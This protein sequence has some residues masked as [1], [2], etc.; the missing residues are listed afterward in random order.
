MKFNQNACC[1]YVFIS[2]EKN[3][4]RCVMFLGL[5]F[6]LCE[7]DRPFFSTFNS[8]GCKMKGLKAVNLLKI[9]KKK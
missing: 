5:V 9:E 1:C 4:I 3:M 2:L 7:Y 6:F 8:F